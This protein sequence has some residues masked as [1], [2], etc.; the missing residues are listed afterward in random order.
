LL[1]QN[2][3]QAAVDAGTLDVLQATAAGNPP[4]VW[5]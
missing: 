5:K 2:A 1:P 4:S 3:P